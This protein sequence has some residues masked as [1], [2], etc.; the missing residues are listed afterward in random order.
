[1]CQKSEFTEQLKQAEKESE[2]EDPVFYCQHCL[3]LKIL[4]SEKTSVSYCGVC[5]NTD[6]MRTSIEFWEDLYFE[7]NGRKYLEQTE[8]QIFKKV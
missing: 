6:I 1:M 3:S 5:G 7:E 8:V 2:L 4:E